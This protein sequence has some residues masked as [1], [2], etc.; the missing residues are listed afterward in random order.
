MEVIYIISTRE[1]AKK[2]LYK[3]GKHTG[4][5]R[6][7]ESRYTTPLINPIIH[8]FHPTPEAS[9]IE[10]ELKKI[11]HEHRVIN[12]TPLMQI[13]MKTIYKY[14]NQNKLN[15]TE[16]DNPGPDKMYINDGVYAKRGE[17]LYDLFCS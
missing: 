1:R 11:L 5:L 4:T 2:N 13:I 7:L 10:N 9:L 17:Y 6:K 16:P 8:F 3:P 14:E 12:L 15:D